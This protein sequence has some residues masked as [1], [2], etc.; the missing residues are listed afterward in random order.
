MRRVTC[1]DGGARRTCAP[2]AI[3]DRRCRNGQPA[4]Y[5]L[6]NELDC[7][8][9]ARCGVEPSHFH[10][11]RIQPGT[12]L[13][14]ISG[15]E[16]LP[17]PDGLG[18]DTRGGRRSGTHLAN[19]QCEA[20][21]KSQSLDFSRP[22]WPILGLDRQPQSSPPPAHRRRLA[23]CGTVVGWAA[24]SPQRSPAEHRQGPARLPPRR[25]EAFGACWTCAARVRSS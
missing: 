22:F 17:R 1:E 9:R 21:Q 19:P 3:S 24:H 12:V 5:F 4:M 2:R 14:N 23:I 11:M 18:G 25:V 15:N 7:P 10:C 6:R 16:V 20:F 8:R 13:A